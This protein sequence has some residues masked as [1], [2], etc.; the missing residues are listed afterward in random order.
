MMVRLEEL[1]RESSYKAQELNDMSKFIRQRGRMS[2]TE[3]VEQSNNL[4][5]LKPMLDVA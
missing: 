5:N 2:L 4:I 3:L 1:T